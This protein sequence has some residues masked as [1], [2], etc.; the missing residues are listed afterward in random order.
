MVA[1]YYDEFH[2]EYWQIF[3]M[4]YSETFN[5]EECMYANAAFADGFARILI[6][7]RT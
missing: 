3:D 6:K 4:D 5:C 7:V 2:A 1:V